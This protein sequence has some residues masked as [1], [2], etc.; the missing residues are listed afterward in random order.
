MRLARFLAAAGGSF[1]AVATAITLAG[2]QPSFPPGPPGAPFPGSPPRTIG[3]YPPMPAPGAL[4]Y[5]P[6]PSAIGAPGQ[7]PGQPKPRRTPFTEPPA[8]QLSE[9]LFKEFSE[10]TER[11]ED[12]GTVLYEFATRN[13][14]PPTDGSP[15]LERAPAPAASPPPTVVM[16]VTMPPLSPLAAEAPPPSPPAGLATLTVVGTQGGTAILRGSQNTY[17]VTDA[18]T[19]TIESKRMLARVA[20]KTVRL[21]DEHG[22]VVYEGQ[23]GSGTSAEQRAASTRNTQVVPAERANA[24]PAARS[25]QRQ[26]LISGGAD[27]GARPVTD[28]GPS[29]PGMDSSV[30]A[31]S[32]PGTTPP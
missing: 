25:G 29:T 17:F 23:V 22:R 28:P 31:P 2:A 9:Q 7:L 21:I 18:Q 5:R 12:P 30:R 20:G 14:L 32:Y 6:S 11:G 1:L 16:P 24:G 26:S 27:R 13:A 19:F 3:S 4:S 15:S 10:R 8:N